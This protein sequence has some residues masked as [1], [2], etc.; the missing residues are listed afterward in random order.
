MVEQATLR[1]VTVRFFAAAEEAA[2]RGEQ[3]VELPV[4]A[5]LGDLRAALVE[6]HGAAMERV[7]TVAAFLLGDELTR[8]LDVPV[9]ARVDVLPP[10]AGG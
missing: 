7:L 10:F 6:R 9:A 5:T 1:A 3:S 2:G 4:G 8:D